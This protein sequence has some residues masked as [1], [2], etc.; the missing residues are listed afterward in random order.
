MIKGGCLCGAVRY[1][2]A[3]DPLFQAFCHCRDCQRASG[4]GHMPVIGV[5]KAGFSTTGDTQTFKAKNSTG[6]RHFC[7]IC[8]SLLFGEPGSVPDV[9]T[10]Y[11]GTL[12]DPNAFHPEM[13]IFVKDRPQWDAAPPDIPAFAEFPPQ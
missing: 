8:G 10:I 6:T 13:R 5:S 3:G 1:E 7:P 9:M 12:D 2:A 11:V 4:S